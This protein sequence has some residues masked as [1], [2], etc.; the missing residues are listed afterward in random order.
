[1]TVQII[2]ELALGLNVFF[3]WGGLCC[4]E[5]EAVITHLC[6]SNLL[7]LITHAGS[8]RMLTLHRHLFK[9]YI[10]CNKVDDREFSIE[11]IGARGESDKLFNLNL[12][13]S[14]A[15]ALSKQ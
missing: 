7:C 8:H 9:I 14:G 5:K 6:F 15:M 1:M 3:R 2:F 4:F 13:F 12:A 11:N 10:S